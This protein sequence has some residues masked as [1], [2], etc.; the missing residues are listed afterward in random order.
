MPPLPGRDPRPTPDEYPLEEAGRR[1][2][3]AADYF[4]R[5]L[6]AHDKTI[7]AVGCRDVLL[8]V[9]RHDDARR[10]AHLMADAGLAQ[11]QRP[12]HDPQP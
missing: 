11:V 7:A 1:Y 5:V 3:E 4:G 9:A 10:L 2:L 8:V 6:S 12:P